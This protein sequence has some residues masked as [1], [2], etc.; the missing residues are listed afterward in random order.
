MISVVYIYIYIYIYYAVKRNPLF[1]IQFHAKIMD[2]FL[3]YLIYIYTD[4]AY[5]IIKNY[6]ELIKMKVLYNHVI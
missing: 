2:F 5:W 1:S 6:Q 3:L 4:L